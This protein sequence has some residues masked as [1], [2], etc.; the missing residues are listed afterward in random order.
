MCNRLRVCDRHSLVSDLCRSA[1]VIGVDVYVFVGQVVGPHGRFGLAGVEV[2]VHPHFARGHIDLGAI[3]P[4]AASLAD[5]HAVDVDINMRRVE[6]CD[7]RRNR[8]QRAE[9]AAPVRVVAADRAFE[10]VRCGDGTPAGERRV[11]T[12]CPVDADADVVAGAFTVAYDLAGEG[13][14]CLTDEIVEL[15]RVRLHAGSA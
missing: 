6:W 13:C 9:D 2:D 1:L 11:F 12:G 4:G 14:A 5:A 7:T 15:V 3:T 10:Q 8:A